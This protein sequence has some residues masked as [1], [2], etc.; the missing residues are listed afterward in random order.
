MRVGDLVRS[1][2]GIG[3]H[4][5][6]RSLPG[7]GGKLISRIKNQT[8]L[9]LRLQL[10]VKT[11]FPDQNPIDYAQVLSQSGIGWIEVHFL[12]IIE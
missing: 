7:G 2:E 1:K 6:I 11:W 5:K 3:Y 8:M 10:G 4:A 12:E 9:I